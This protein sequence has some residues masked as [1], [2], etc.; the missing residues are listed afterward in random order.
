MRWFPRAVI[1]LLTTG[2]SVLFGLGCI[3]AALFEIQ[4]FGGPPDGGPRP[5]YLA[6]LALAFIVCIAAPWA[7][8][9]AYD[10]SVAAYE[11]RGTRGLL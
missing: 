5:F 2:L 1:F 8:L 10:R 4:G 6:A 11:K 7:V 3:L 9:R